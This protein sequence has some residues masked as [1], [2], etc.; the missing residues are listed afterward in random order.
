MTEIMFK[1][2]TVETPRIID[3]LNDVAVKLHDRVTLKVAA[4][5]EETM[6][7]MWQK[8]VNRRTKWANVS[9][10]SKYSGQGTPTLVI[11]D[12]EDKDEGL[13]RCVVSSEGGETVTR[14]ASLRIS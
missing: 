5:C 13:F 6:T 4:V 2:F 1:M 3:D 10:G 12:V 14:E 7:Y 8:R 11:T 9:S